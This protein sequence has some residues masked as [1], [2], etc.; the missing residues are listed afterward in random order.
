[1]RLDVHDLSPDTVGTFDYVFCAGVL[2]HLK[3][4]FYALEKMRSVTTDTL[5]IETHAMILAMHQQYALSAFF[6]GDEDAG[7]WDVCGYT[8]L[9]WLKEAV[10]YAGFKSCEF[11]HTPSSYLLK[12]LKAFITNKP[13][14]GRVIVHAK[15]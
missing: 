1:L 14:S 7:R 12:K 13:Q 4:P 9:A 10:K 11:K 8:T 5:I 2:Y 3:H 6:P 15:V